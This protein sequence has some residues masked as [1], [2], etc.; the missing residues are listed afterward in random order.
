MKKIFYASIFTFCFGVFLYVAHPVYAASHKLFTIFG[1]IEMLLEKGIVSETNAEKARYL[2]SFIEKVDAPQ[3]EVVQGE[4]ALRD[5]FEDIEVRV[6]QFIENGTRTYNTYE[7]VQGLILTVKNTTSEEILLH[8]IRKCQVVYRIFN[9]KAELL[10]DSS[11]GDACQTGE[12]VVYTLL[13]GKTRIF[14]ITHKMDAY[15]LEKGV[16]R[17]EIEYPEYGKGNVSVT[18]Q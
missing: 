9:E 12:K 1:F 2:A 14:P 8:A 7:D 16:Y 3:K 13:A 11:K 18:I 6:S 10:Y 15:Q 17:F 5:D 4:E